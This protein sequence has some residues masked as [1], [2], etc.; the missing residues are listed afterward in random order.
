MEFFDLYGKHIG[1]LIAWL[2]KPETNIPAI[3][4]I[5]ATAALLG[6]IISVLGFYKAWK[7]AEKRLGKRLDEF[8]DHEEEKLQEA[9]NAIRALREQRSIASNR[10]RLFSNGELRS[11][12]RL[13]GKRRYGA[14]KLELTEAL[15]RTQERADLAD[16]KRDLHERQRAMAH[17]LLGAVA[18]AENDH[19]TALTHFQS[20]LT[21]NADDL[22][23]REYVGIELLKLGNPVQALDEFSKLAELAE[24][25]ENKLLQAQALRNCGLALEALPVPARRDAYSS[26]KDA[27][28]LYPPNGSPLELAQIYELCASASLRLTWRR[29]TYSNLMHALTS[30]SA[31]AY[32]EN[33]EA[34]IAR[35]GVERVMA[36]L[37]ELQVLP[38]SA[39]G[40][41]NG[42]G[43]G[44]SDE[45]IVSASETT[46]ASFISSQ[47]HLPQQSPNGERPN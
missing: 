26:Y 32:G 1:E 41:G 3:K 47:Q 19:G 43:N 34:K 23:A 2:S 44:D 20:A 9:R 5:Q 6:A 46:P 33:N 4:L 15:S 18:D 39:D 30:Y 40:S 11:A 25:V 24:R 35:E 10:S 27:I 37:K 14:A 17:M 31:I 36:A 7:F 29:R 12:L 38:N 13:V 8:L 45:A 21:I 22:E 28:S 16:K 42:D